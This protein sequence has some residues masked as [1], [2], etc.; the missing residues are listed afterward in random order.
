M[1]LLGDA[2]M[3]EELENRHVILVEDIVDTG[4]TVANLLPK[5]ESYGTKSV[6]VCTLL[7]KRLDKG[8]QPAAKAKYSGFSIPNK[9]IIGYGLDYNGRKR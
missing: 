7:E 6:Q 3:K 8:T 2:I 4:T 9:F 1:K 5:V